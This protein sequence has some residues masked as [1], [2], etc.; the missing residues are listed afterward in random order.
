MLLLNVYLTLRPWIWVTLHSAN[1]YPILC[2]GVKEL[3]ILE[4]FCVFFFGAGMRNSF[5]G[6]HKWFESGKIDTFLDS[7]KPPLFSTKSLK[8]PKSRNVSNILKLLKICNLSRNVKIRT[9]LDRRFSKRCTKNRK[10]FNYKHKLSDMREWDD[11]SG[12]YIYFFYHSLLSHY[13]FYYF[14]FFKTDTGLAKNVALA[15]KK[16]SRKV[17]I[18]FIREISDFEK[19]VN[20]CILT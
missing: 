12:A 3:K 17:S 18:F 5:V 13:P 15:V 16:L 11:V 20:C 19:S 7:A 9:F 1:V 14:L 10:L 2:H 4:F 8:L 6:L